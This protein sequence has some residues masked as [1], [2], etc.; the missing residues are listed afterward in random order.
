MHTDYFLSDI[1]I[2]SFT[3]MKIGTLN[4]KSGN[5][6]EKYCHR[7]LASPLSGLMVLFLI[8]LWLY[9]LLVLLLCVS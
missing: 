2:D 8:L 6:V 3:H 7:R 5:L 9:N 4:G 1:I